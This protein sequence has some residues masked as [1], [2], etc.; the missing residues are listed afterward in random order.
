MENKITNIKVTLDIAKTE[1]SDTET[2]LIFIK[3]NWNNIELITK[4]N[5][6]EIQNLKEIILSFI[7]FSRKYFTEFFNKTDYIEEVGNFLKVIIFFLQVCRRF[8]HSYLHSKGN[9]YA[10]VIHK[11]LIHCG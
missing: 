2:Y 5:S 4:L 6:Q 11:S 8:Y 3:N 10:P 1:I 9:F 7:N